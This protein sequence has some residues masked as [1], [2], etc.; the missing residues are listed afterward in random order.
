MEDP[1]GQFIDIDVIIDCSD[2]DIK[3]NLLVLLEKKMT[4]LQ[5]AARY[6]EIL[7]NKFQWRSKVVS[8]ASIIGTGLSFVMSTVMGQSENSTNV[9][10]AIAS[11]V[12]LALK[13]SKQYCNFGEKAAAH[14]QSQIAALDLAD[15]I[16][17]VILKNNHTK[18]SL[19]QAL[20]IYEERIKSFR[21]SE[22]PIPLD[23]KLKYG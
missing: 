3:R 23:I 9:P 12:A 21:K 11:G 8:Y 14:A 20:D 6:H 19:Q 10:L 2:D 1:N 15:D 5:I 16:E 17:Y 4:S 7:A 18:V 22:A 13:G